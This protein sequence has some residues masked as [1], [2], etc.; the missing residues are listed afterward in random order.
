MDAD[1]TGHTEL[2]DT[3]ACAI[4]VLKSDEPDPDVPRPVSRIK[5]GRRNPNYGRGAN[6]PVIYSISPSR[7]SVMGGSL[8][9]IEGRNLGDVLS[10][11]GEEGRQGTSSIL[12]YFERDGIQSKCNLITH[13]HNPTQIFCVLD[14]LSIEQY[15]ELFVFI[16]G[17]RVQTTCGSCYFQSHRN[18][19]DRIEKLFS[20]NLV[21]PSGEPQWTNWTTGDASNQIWGKVYQQ[22]ST[23]NNQYHCTAPLDV[24]MRYVENLELVEERDVTHVGSDNVTC[25]EEDGQECTELQFRYL[26]DDSS[27]KIQMNGKGHEGSFGY[28]NV[29]ELSD[30]HIMG[31][32]VET[33]SSTP[34]TVAV[35]TPSYE[36]EGGEIHQMEIYSFHST[37]YGMVNCRIDSDQVGHFHLNVRTMRDGRSRMSQMYTYFTNEGQVATF[38]LAPAIHSISPSEGSV[39]GGTFL[40][41]TGRSLSTD[42]H[43]S[44]VLVGGEICEIITATA[45]KIVCQTHKPA[46]VQE[47]YAGGAGATQHIFKYEQT[48]MYSLV[49]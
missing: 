43:T 26:C 14:P 37:W 28:H 40:T 41:I 12:V 35:C 19:D 18:Y 5:D 17:D 27:V 48:G 31:I 23:I 45:T 11:F 15:F 42:Y 39:E 47:I 2:C 29:N 34:T 8:I 6:V 3:S 38:T 20:G 25:N 44:S 36:D 10:S 22:H 49:H 13:Y 24:Q 9:T 1:A 33:I 32:N 16:N 30:N 7:G 46:A 21:S 4:F